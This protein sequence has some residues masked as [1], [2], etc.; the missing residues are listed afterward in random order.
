MDDNKNEA[1]RR[2]TNIE[3][4]LHQ[5]DAHGTNT[6]GEKKRGPRTLHS[7]VSNINSDHILPLLN[8]CCGLDGDGPYSATGLAKYAGS[9]VSFGSYAL[10]AD[11]LLDKLPVADGC[12]LN[13]ACAPDPSPSDSG[14]ESGDRVLPKRCGVDPAFMLKLLPC[15]CGLPCPNGCDT[16]IDGTDSCGE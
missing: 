1:H 4:F 11:R 10:Y 15:T 12:F 7:L 16:E 9:K 14:D 13:L 2:R 5:S 8:L 3:S 6:Q